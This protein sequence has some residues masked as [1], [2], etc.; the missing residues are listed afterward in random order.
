MMPVYGDSC[1]QM[2]CFERKEKQYIAAAAAAKK[3]KNIKI[4]DNNN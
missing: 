4:E 3:K 2:Q 1:T